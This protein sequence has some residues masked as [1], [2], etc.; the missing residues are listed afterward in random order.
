LDKPPLLSTAQS[1]FA[2][3]FGM[4]LTLH[5]GPVT[6][7]RNRA[8]LAV[9][10]PQG[11]D[12]PLAI[13]LFA[14]GTHDVLTI[15]DCVAHHGRLNAAAAAVCQTATELG[16]QPYD[17]TSRQGALRY[18][19]LETRGVAADAAVD[20]TLVW[21]AD[22]SGD[23]DLRRVADTLLTEHGELFSSVWVNRNTTA[24][25]AVVDVRLEQWQRLDGRLEDAWHWERFG[26]ADVAYTPAAFLQANYGAFDALCTHVGDLVPQG[27]RV[28]DVFAGTGALGLS[29]LA[30]GICSQ[31]TAIEVTP[32]AAAAFHV[33]VTRLDAHARATMHIVDAGA[34]DALDILAGSG[35]D[36]AIVDPPRKGLDASLLNALSDP[37]RLRSIRRLVYISCGF[38]ALQRDA[39]ALRRHG[40]VLARPPEAWQFF[41]GTDALETV[42]V[43]DR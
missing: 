42:A 40:W 17:E 3:E 35:V 27:S 14:A 43:F 1:F 26:G 38:K 16:I 10:R 31:L 32:G 19:Q 22:A 2:K 34:Q 7:W 8:R 23:A 33:A 13:G 30:R 41:P 24:G 6:G 9:R 29:L 12:S 20:A 21:A 11:S 28:A 5:T 37:Q 39:L 18:L 4:S 15:P 25:N 36:V